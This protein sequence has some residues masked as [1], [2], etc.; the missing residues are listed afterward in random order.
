[1]FYLVTLICA[2]LYSLFIIFIITGL[3]RHDLSEISL[4]KELPKVSVVIA[5]RNEEKNLPDLI[6]DLVNQEYPLNKLEIIFIDDRSSDQT[7]AILDKASGD[8]GFINY[9]SITEKSL[10]MTPKK[11]AL[12]IG[13]DSAVGDIIVSTD[14]DCRVGHLWVSSMAYSVINNNSISIGYSKIKG[15]LFFENYQKIDFLGIMAA[16]AGA[17]GWNQFWSGSGQNL[18]YFKNDFTIIDGFNPVKE[19]ISGDDMYLVQSITKFRKGIINIDKNSFVET[20]PMKT[21]KGF[22]NQRIR[23]SSN[24]KLNFRG[25]LFF[26]SF[27]LSTLLINC[28]ILISL[29]TNQFLISLFLLKLIC[30]GLVLFFGSKLFNTNISF[31][32][33][34]IWSIIQ[35]F[36]IPLISIL[37]L[38]EKFTWNQ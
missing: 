27:L 9:I 2:V 28:N 7:K 31:I 11:H 8:Y 3:F 34:L 12:T 18:A 19:K 22:I 5:A 35:P 1:M 24:A 20:E 21:V 4:S 30:D 15:S 13:I 37:G 26:F 25:N 16:N 36:Y 17:G 38:K 14:A 23:W 29:L 32:P 33:F 6:H 10:E